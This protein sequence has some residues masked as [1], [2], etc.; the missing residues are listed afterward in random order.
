MI[1]HEAT[2]SAS[3]CPLAERELDSDGHVGPSCVSRPDVRRATHR[4]RRRGRQ[5]RPP[6]L[7]VHSG[8]VAQTDRV[9]CAKFK[10]GRN[11]G[12]RPQDGAATRGRHARQRRIVPRRSNQR[13][14]VTS[15]RAA[16]QRRLAGAVFA[17]MAT[18]A[19][20][21]SVNDTSS[22]TTRDV[23]GYANDTCSSR[24]P[25]VYAVG[26]ARSPHAATEAA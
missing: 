9:S 20:Y 11:P 19:P 4:R 3:F 13:W 1:A 23:P 2:A 8:D 25:A 26:T 21:G 10:S 7:V 5:P 12:T 22:S 15:S 14:L 16:D 17:T 6:Q 18:T 24:M